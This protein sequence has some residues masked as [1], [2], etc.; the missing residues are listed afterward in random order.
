MTI[1]PADSLEARVEIPSNKIGFIRTG[2]ESDVSID[3]Y[4]ATDFGV[5][6]GVVRKIGSDAL[7]PEPSQGIPAYYF[8]VDI[9]LKINHYIK[10]WNNITTANRNEPKRKYQIAK[11]KHLQL[12]LGGLK[13]ASKSLTER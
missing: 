3:S 13:D 8:P 11:S 7:P 10:Q 1:V 9:Q 12:L 6:E 2:Q 4:R 5:I